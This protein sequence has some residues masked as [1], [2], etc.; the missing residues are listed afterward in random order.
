M[1]G[2]DR[3]RLRRV[4]IVDKNGRTT[5]RW[6][7]VE[8]PHPAAAEGGISEGLW[9][10]LPLPSPT[11]QRLTA[12]QR[13]RE[14]RRRVRRTRRRERSVVR[15]QLRAER[16]E[17]KRDAVSLA[18]AQAQL[19][20]PQSWPTPV[21][22]FTQRQPGGAVTVDPWA[23]PAVKRE[24]RRAVHSAVIPDPQAAYRLGGVGVH[25]DGRVYSPTP[26]AWSDEMW[27]YT[28]AH[29]VPVALG[30]LT[31]VQYSLENSVLPEAW[32]AE[33]RQAAARA[34]F[35]AVDGEVVATYG[36]IL[37][38]AV[39]Q[40]LRARHA[41]AEGRYHLELKKTQAVA[42]SFGYPDAR[43]LWATAHT[44]RAAVQHRAL[45][46]AYDADAWNVHTTV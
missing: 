45:S 13:E 42:E 4:K 35:D 33:T 7:R 34:E 17:A 22:L 3:R 38:D 26:G 2:L 11:A 20:T 29:G 32:R 15:R 27:A 14:E 10:G 21:P 1:A 25:V 12:R 46:R 24:A 5:H 36:T 40:E 44:V 6:R 8:E 9:L 19:R 23:S 39:P 18:R 43:S 37:S 30:S 41:A 16:A 28:R 31:Q